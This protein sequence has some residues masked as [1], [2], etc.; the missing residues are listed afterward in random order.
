M[1]VLV[2]QARQK[3]LGTLRQWEKEISLLLPCFQINSLNFK[4]L[5]L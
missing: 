1:R 4:I 2:E 3:L 5:L